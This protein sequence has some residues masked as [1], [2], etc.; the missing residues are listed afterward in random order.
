[1]ITIRKVD[2]TNKE[3]ERYLKIKKLVETNGNKNRATVE[4]GCT[5]RH[6]NRMILGYKK[7]GK[8][9]FVHGNRNRKPAHSLDDKTKQLVIDLYLTKYQDANFAH[10]SQVTSKI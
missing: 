10:Y 1:M 4:L 9:Y 8:A 5:L 2:L 6:V 3:N 7:K